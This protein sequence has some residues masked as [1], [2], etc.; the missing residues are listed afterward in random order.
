MAGPASEAPTYTT[1]LRHRHLSVRATLHSRPMSRHLLTPS[2]LT[3]LAV[4]G[5]GAPAPT[6]PDHGHGEIWICGAG[7]LYHGNGPQSTGTCRICVPVPAYSPGSTF[8]DLASRAC[9]EPPSPQTAS[10]NLHQRQGQRDHG[11]AIGGG[12]QPGFFLYLCCFL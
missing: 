11:L 5:G 6:Q 12:N 9:V 7:S 4:V 3:A 10:P 2:H 8:N 1:A